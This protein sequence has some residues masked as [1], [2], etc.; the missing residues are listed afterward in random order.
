MF[1]EIGLTNDGLSS[2]EQALFWIVAVGCYCLL[3]ANVIKRDLLKSLL[4]G[5]PSLAMF[6]WMVYN[7]FLFPSLFANEQ[8]D[9]TP[10][11]LLTCFLVVLLVLPVISAWLWFSPKPGARKARFILLAAEILCLIIVAVLARYRM[12][13]YDDDITRFLVESMRD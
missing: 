1:G 3:L 2:F 12:L 8:T 11:I 4:W 13:A 7:D 6:G 9:W 10:Q 5:V